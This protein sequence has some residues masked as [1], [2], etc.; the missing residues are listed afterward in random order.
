MLI[1]TLAIYIIV[2]LIV[3]WFFIVARMHTLKFKNFSTH[4]VPITNSL[5]IFLIILS[6]SWFIFI[7]YINSGNST[8]EVNVERDIIEEKVE[9]KVEEKKSYENEIIWDDYY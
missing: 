5:M 9:K 6:I 4:I 2:L 7:F 8:Y 1:W 3:W